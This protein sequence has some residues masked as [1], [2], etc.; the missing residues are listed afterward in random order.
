ML[1]LSQKLLSFLIEL[2]LLGYHALDFFLGSDVVAG[3]GG[4]I[5]G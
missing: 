2:R 1:L 4:C 3:N 5:D